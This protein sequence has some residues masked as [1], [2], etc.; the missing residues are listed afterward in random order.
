[1]NLVARLRALWRLTEH[2]LDVRRIECSPTDIIVVEVEQR[3]SKETM[4]SI[5][6]ALKGIFDADRKIVILDG[7]GKLHVLAQSQEKLLL[8]NLACVREG[9][10]PMRGSGA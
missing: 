2:D 6:M 9:L 8:P 1:M 7:G 10:D 5:G 3:L 4:Y